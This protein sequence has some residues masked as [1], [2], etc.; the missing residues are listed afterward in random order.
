MEHS[1]IYYFHNDGEPKVYGGSADVMVRSFDRRIESLFLFVNPLVKQQ[2][3]NI[4]AYNLR[5]NMNTYIMQ[6]DG[7]YLP[8]QKGRAAAFDIH[9]EFFK[10]TRDEVKQAKL[11]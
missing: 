11:F 4:L 3:I 7:D 10:L 5:D 9:K 1:R 2:I 8:R 6:E